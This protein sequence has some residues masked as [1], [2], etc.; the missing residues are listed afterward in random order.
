MM[1][2]ILNGDFNVWQS[3]TEFENVSHY[4]LVADGYR[5]GLESNSTTYDISRDEDSPTDDT[6]YSLKVEADGAET[7]GESHLRHAIEGYDIE[8]VIGDDM[9]I[10]FYVKSSTVGTYSVAFHLPE[11]NKTLVKEYDIDTA[12]TWEKQVMT[13]DLPSNYDYNTTNGIGLKIRFNWAC[14][15]SGYQAPSLNQWNSGNHTGSSTQDSFATQAGDYISI[16]RIRANP[17]DEE[18]EVFKRSYQEELHACRRRLMVFNREM[19]ERTP[20]SSVSV[21]SI[22]NIYIPLPNQLRAVPNVYVTGT[23]G[24]DWQLRGI[25]D[26]INTTGLQRWYSGELNSGTMMGKIRFTLGTYSA[27]YP[28]HIVLITD[29]TKI[30]FDAEF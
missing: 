2:L 24:T 8:E 7:T 17:G 3:G 20:L 28:Y 5:Y 11:E 9:T 19:M 22:L 1:N 30:I 25:N 23:R 27:G 29:N 12:N 21:S 18:K 4:S 6:R 16:A 15:I 13:I 26:S 10:S 14:N